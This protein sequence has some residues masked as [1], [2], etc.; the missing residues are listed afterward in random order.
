M[1]AE[2][3]YQEKFDFVINCV[4]FE[5]IFLIDRTP[6]ELL[7]GAQSSYGRFATILL[8][9]RGFR[10]EL[11]DNDYYQIC[12]ILNLSYSEN[13]FTSAKFLTEL[14][15]Q[16][17]SK[18]SSVCVQPHQIARYKNDIPD[19]EKIYFLGWNNHLVD[20]RKARNFDKTRK[21]LGDSVADFCIKH[22]I[23]SCWTDNPKEKEPYLYPP[24]FTY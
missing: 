1:K 13:H 6:F 22:N 17:P 2:K 9:E 5:A 21:L 16:V 18:C 7:I 20:K 12:K 8:V 11:S 14:D 24:G 15:N 3:K 4:R 19:S 23:S 10:T